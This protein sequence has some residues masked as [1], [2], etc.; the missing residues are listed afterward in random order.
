[1][2]SI[3]STLGGLV[4]SREGQTLQSE[5]QQL[6]GLEVAVNGGRVVAKALSVLSLLFENGGV[7]YTG[8]F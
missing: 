1:M 4:S 5:N 8:G 3:L 6:T 2:D 7:G